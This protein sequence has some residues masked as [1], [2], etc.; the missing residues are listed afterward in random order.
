MG[1]YVATIVSLCFLHVVDV[2]ASSICI[3]LRAFVA[4]IYMCLLYASL[5]SSVSRSNFGLMSW[6]V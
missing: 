1:V 6:G 4:V 2:S 3:V 5:G